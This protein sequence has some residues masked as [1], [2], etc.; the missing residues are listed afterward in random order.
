MSW[1][2]YHSSSWFFADIQQH[3]NSNSSTVF[4]FTEQN[5]Y[6]SFPQSQSFRSL[7][8]RFANFSSEVDVVSRRCPSDVSSSPLFARFSIVCLE[9]RAI[10]LLSRTIYKPPLFA[11]HVCCYTL[12]YVI[13]A[14]SQWPPELR[15]WKSSLNT[16]VSQAWKDS[17]QV[18]RFAHRSQFSRKRCQVV[19]EQSKSRPQ[20]QGFLYGFGMMAQYFF[21]FAS[22][23]LT[24]LYPT[25]HRKSLNVGFSP[26]AFAHRF[27]AIAAAFCLCAYVDSFK[28]IFN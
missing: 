4:C 8:L 23:S 20:T 7:K 22:A 19:W 25:W 16:G 28:L 9:I 1:R 10:E 5:S 6:F 17:S 24:F 2:R 21:R 15:L 14:A 11:V 26:S 13:V 3:S 12:L 27:V 18:H